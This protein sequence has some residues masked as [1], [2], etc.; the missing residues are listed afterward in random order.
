MPSNSPP[1]AIPSYRK[2][3][4]DQIKNS[5]EILSFDPSDF[6][7]KPFL[8]YVLLHWLS[9]LKLN[10][11]GRPVD[12]KKRVT[13]DALLE[14]R[15]RHKFQGLHCLCPLLRTTNEEYPLTEAKIQLKASGDYIGEYIAECPNG[16]CEYFGQL[17]DAYQEK[18]SLT[19]RK[20]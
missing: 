1:T 4:L 8:W 16:L 10:L 2:V 3:L 5:R 12:G 11:E 17:P 20:K 13:P 6:E 15:A 7:L 14:Y 9:N 18:E 19:I